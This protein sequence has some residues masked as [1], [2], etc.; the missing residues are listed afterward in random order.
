MKKKKEDK[1]FK[2][3]LEKCVENNLAKGFSLSRI[4]QTFLIGGYSEKVVDDL[5]E[6]Y[7]PRSKIPII[8]ALLLFI[9]IFTVTMQPASLTGNVILSQGNLQRDNIGKE[10]SSS[11]EYIWKPTNL[12]EINSI[13]LNG[14]MSHDT[15][16]KVYLENEGVNYVLFDSNSLNNNFI[17]NSVVKE[18]QGAISIN[19]DYNI[20]SEGIFDINDLVEFNLDA[21]FN[22]KTDYNKICTEWQIKSID[23]GNDVNF[24]NGNQD[25]C[26]TL[27]INLL[28]SSWDEPLSISYGA[29]GT[30][31]N[32]LVKVR[33]IHL[34]DD[35]NHISSDYAQL[36]FVFQEEFITFKKKCEETCLLNNIY[37]ESYK[38]SIEVEQGEIFI[39]SILYSLAEDKTD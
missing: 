19:L 32:N 13:L 38:L 11:S 21:N 34:E 29:A 5:I 2:K 37:S 36:P 17:T 24:C 4:K 27:N 12:S 23:S 28:A 18:T 6:K 35:T 39:D 7:Q 16:A 31:Y 8:A 9:L 15:I 26:D 33:V 1:A 10:F 20:N 25:C 14:K 30:R 3:K 22:F